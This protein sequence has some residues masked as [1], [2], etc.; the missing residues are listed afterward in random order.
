M[1]LVAMLHCVGCESDMPPISWEGENVRFGTNHDEM[2][3]GSTLERLD[4]T[5]GLLMERLEISLPSN[6]KITYYWVDADTVRKRCGQATACSYSTVVMSTDPIQQH[7]LVHAVTSRLGRKHRLLGEGLAVAYGEPDSRYWDS[8]FTSAANVEEQMVPNLDRE[9]M[10]YG[11]AGRFVRY[12]IE[13]HGLDALKKLVSL[14]D[15]GSGKQEFDVA[16]REATGLTIRR[17]LDD[18]DAAMLGHCL[19]YSSVPLCSSGPEGLSQWPV[20]VD[21][22]IGCEQEGSVGPF[23][24]S[25][26]MDWAKGDDC[27]M[28]SFQIDTEPGEFYEVTVEGQEG[29]SGQVIFRACDFNPQCLYHGLPIF[30]IDTPGSPG[31]D[32]PPGTLF[33]IL[34]EGAIW[35]DVYVY[36]TPGESGWVRV[37]VEEKTLMGPDW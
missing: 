36:E 34:T 31:N 37:S 1:A 19:C 4:E 17:L 26:S 22:E 28:R 20:I 10:E 13:T 16:C 18:F 32:I 15:A 14:T 2:P 23:S 25:G 33:T 24:D 7:E 21:M 5:V 29:V 8:C 12:L 3:C 6:Q 30:S 9:N 11:C 27:L 35:V